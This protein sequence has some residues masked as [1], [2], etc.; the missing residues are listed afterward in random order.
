MLTIGQ[1]ATLLREKYRCPSLTEWH[2]RRTIRAG[3]C[4]E[5][6]RVGRYRA[7]TDGD[8]AAMEAALIE[9]GWLPKRGKK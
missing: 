2:I 7:F 9:A 4:P 8:V 1:V 5:P 6:Q 3:K